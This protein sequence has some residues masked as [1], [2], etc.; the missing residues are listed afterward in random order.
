MNGYFSVLKINLFSIV[1]QSVGVKIILTGR[2]NY[3]HRAVGFYSTLSD[4]LLSG[5]WI[6]HDFD[7][8]FD[9]KYHFFIVVAAS[10]YNVVA[11]ICLALT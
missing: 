8:F 1:C 11:T 3:L 10:M 2:H 6:I 7:G 4:N 5:L 9:F